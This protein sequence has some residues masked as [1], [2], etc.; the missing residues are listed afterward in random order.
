[1][2][3]SEILIKKDKYLKKIE[4]VK[5]STRW[6]HTLPHFII[7]FLLRLVLVM[8]TKFQGQPVAFHIPLSWNNVSAL[9]SI[10]GSVFAEMIGHPHAIIHD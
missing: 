10:R 9:F 1:M 6:H 5:S 4:D 7:S 8:T 2:I 3:Y